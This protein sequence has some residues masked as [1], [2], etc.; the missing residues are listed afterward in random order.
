MAGSSHHCAD[1]ISEEIYCD[2]DLGGSANLACTLSQL[3]N[4]ATI[5]SYTSYK[6]RNVSSPS[7]STFTM[8][9]RS[10][11]HSKQATR[12]GRWNIH[13]I[14]RWLAVGP[15]PFGLADGQKPA[16]LCPHACWKRYC[17]KKTKVGRQKGCSAHTACMMRL[18]RSAYCHLL[19]LFG[20]HSFSQVN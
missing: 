8:H 5:A 6:V 20:Q 7:I 1:R 2:R 4:K 17:S 19:L 3:Y 14:Y 12:T 11:T 10:A 18:L 9:L 15:A 16:C 13:L